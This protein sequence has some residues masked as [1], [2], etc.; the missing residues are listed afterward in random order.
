[1]FS[2]DV[3]FSTL[4]HTGRC[5]MSGHLTISDAKHD[6]WVKVV[7]ARPLLDLLKGGPS[8]CFANLLLIREHPNPDCFSSRGICFSLQG[9]LFPIQDTEWDQLSCLVFIQLVSDLIHQDILQIDKHLFQLAQTYTT[10]MFSGKTHSFINLSMPL[11]STFQREKIICTTEEFPYIVWLCF[12]VLPTMNGTFRKFPHTTRQTDTQ[13]SLQASP[14]ALLQPL[15]CHPDPKP[16]SHPDSCS[17]MSSSLPK[18]N[19]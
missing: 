7:T 3:V 18:S 4:H 2:S 15:S 12:F 14:S 6:F 19:G 16:W 5:A 8:L 17:L 11:A 10:L 9:Y 13:F 1:M